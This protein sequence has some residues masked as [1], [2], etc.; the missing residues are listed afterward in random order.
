M[1]RIKSR[2]TEPEL[3]LRRELWKEGCRYRVQYGEEKIDI[4]F[5]SRKMA[6]FVDGCFWHSCPL[7]GHAPKSNKAYWNGKLSKN[8]ERAKNKDMRLEAKGW[9]IVHFWEHEVKESPPSCAVK[10]LEML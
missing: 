8:L 5:P 6:I 1:A 10:V 4:A 7:H 2:D 9:K 3:I